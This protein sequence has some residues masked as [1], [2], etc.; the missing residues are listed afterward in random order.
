MKLRNVLQT[1]FLRFPAKALHLP[2]R[3]RL[4]SDEVWDSQS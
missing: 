1:V 3:C 2:R 4:V